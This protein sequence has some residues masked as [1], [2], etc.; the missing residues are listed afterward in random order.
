MKKRKNRR[1]LRCEEEMMPSRARVVLDGPGGSLLVFP[2]GLPP[3]G[4]PEAPA[5]QETSPRA[6]KQNRSNTRRR[7]RRFQ[8]GIEMKLRRLPEQELRREFLEVVV[9][10][11]LDLNGEINARLD[12]LLKMKHAHENLDLNEEPLYHL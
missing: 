8:E 12:H 4:P 11:E 1:T 10:E 2:C 9:M 7:M 3:P 5:A 6:H